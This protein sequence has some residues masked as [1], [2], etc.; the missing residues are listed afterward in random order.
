MSPVAGRVPTRVVDA[1]AR[2]RRPLVGAGSWLGRLVLAGILCAAAPPV[3]RS[4]TFPD[5][6]VRESWRLEN[7]LLVRT[8]HVPGAAG[9]AIT[10]AVRAGS[11]YEPA[12]LEGLSELLA[13]VQFTAPAGNLPERKRAEMSSLRPLGWETRPGVRL[14]RFTEIATRQQFPG[15]LQ[16][17][18][19]RLA[20]VSPRDADVQRALADE[21]RD[22]GKRLFGEP[23]DVLYWRAGAMARGMDDAAIVRLAS[24]EAVAKLG[25]KGVTPWLKRWYH[26][27][28]ASLAIAGDLSGVD[29]RALVSSL[30]G[31]LPGGTANPDTVQLRLRG[32]Q[33][34][35]PWKDLE[36]PVGVVAAAGPALTDSLHPGFYLG[37]LITGPALAHS[38]GAPKGPLRSRF[39]YSILDEPELVRFYPPAPPQD[40][41]PAHLAGTLNSALD[42]VAAQSVTA[43]MLDGMRRNV[44]WLLG[45]ELPVDV[46]ARLKKETGGLGTIST[47]LATRALWMGDAFWSSYLARFDG[48][49]LGHQYFYSH[50]SSPE[51][52]TTLLLTPQR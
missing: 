26:A 49:L 38:W 34:S 10:L 28:N 42:A 20:G 24:L 25:A 8:L 21:R 12:G 6:T 44:R 22:M 3:A 51:R 45:A 30:F 46:R 33:R 1:A 43:P 35:A 40:R 52:Q 14:M 2:G 50:L 29:V 36:A 4:E 23:A 5:S 39:Q 9:V 13:E 15:V 31:P 48:A 37:M 11:G 19:R 18:A 27:G 32:G 17:V 16:Q 47:G 7:G 41:E